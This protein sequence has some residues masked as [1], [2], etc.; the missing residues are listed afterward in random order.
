MER[1]IKESSITIEKLK[2]VHIKIQFCRK[3]YCIWW[4]SFVSSTSEV[5]AEITR[6]ITGIFSTYGLI[7]AVV[8]KNMN[9]ELD[10][11]NLNNDREEEF[12]FSLIFNTSWGIKNL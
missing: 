12:D 6:P 11:E 7:K 10:I 4:E 1:L 5:I 2:E 3:W 9:K 8:I